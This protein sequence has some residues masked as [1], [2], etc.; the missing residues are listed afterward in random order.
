MLFRL[1]PCKISK[2]VGLR[3]LIKSLFNC[4]YSNTISLTLNNSNCTAS[5]SWR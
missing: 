2:V 5:R 1:T 4:K 3:Q